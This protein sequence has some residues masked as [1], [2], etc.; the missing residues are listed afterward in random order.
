MPPSTG[1]YIPECRRV[2]SDEFGRVLQA[3]IRRAVREPGL[4]PV[5]TISLAV[6]ALKR[7]SQMPSARRQYL[8]VGVGDAVIS[9]MWAFPQSLMLQTESAELLARLNHKLARHPLMP[10][11]CR[12]PGALD[13]MLRAIRLHLDEDDRMHVENLLN[14]LFSMGYF[15]AR[16]S[17]AGVALRSHRP[18]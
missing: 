7:F 4:P 11:Q 9:A 18:L 14:A 1:R 17:R 12:P 8:R 3:C 2:R 16:R 6:R 15:V 10:F 13:V 5:R